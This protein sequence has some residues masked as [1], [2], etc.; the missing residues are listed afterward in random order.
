MTE[1]Y[2]DYDAFARA[3]DRHWGPE[4]ARTALAVF[5]DL[6]SPRLPT[7][8]NILDLCCGS[9]QLAHLLATK[10]HEVTGVDGS[11]QLLDFAERNAPEATFVLADAR[12]F[13]MPPRF[14]AVLCMS[15]SLNHVLSLSE[16]ASVFCN[17]FAALRDGGLFLFDMN[18]EHKY[19]TSWAGQFSLE[20]CTVRAT[21]DPGTRIARFDATI[22]QRSEVTLLQTWYPEAEILAAL[23]QAGF[24]ILETHPTPDKVY[25]LARRNSA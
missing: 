9:G 12:S 24:S 14:D 17:V 13:V 10:G 3:Y 15:D 16:L 2:S 21:Y 11:Q 4:S 19:V 8:A 23:R 7:P 22:N 6:V 5:D 1:R 20:D 25:F 18:M